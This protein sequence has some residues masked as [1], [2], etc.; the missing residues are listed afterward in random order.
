MNTEENHKDIEKTMTVGEGDIRIKN[1]YRQATCDVDESNVMLD[2]EDIDS[3]ESAPSE[4]FPVGDISRQTL[5]TSRKS[6]GRSKQK[7]ERKCPVV[8]KSPR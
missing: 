6:P 7:S 3:S 8:K 5:K 4:D 1:F 2:R